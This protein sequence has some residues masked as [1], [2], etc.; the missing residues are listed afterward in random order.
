GAK[1]SALAQVTEFGNA[2]RVDA[3]GDVSGTSL[4]SQYFNTQSTLREPWTI[5]QPP[6]S[7]PVTA[8]PTYAASGLV[9]EYPTRDM[10]SN[11]QGDMRTGVFDGSGRSGVVMRTAPSPGSCS[12]S[13]DE[14]TLHGNGELP[15]TLEMPS[16]LTM[17]AGYCHTTLQ[18]SAADVNGD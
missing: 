2:A 13:L 9:D 10:P 4:P 18:W 17:P 1:R 3:S 16:T 12:S 8:A 6:T 7:Q 11:W 14:I 15:S 5:A